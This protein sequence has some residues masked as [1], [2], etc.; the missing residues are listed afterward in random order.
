LP[1]PQKMW[2]GSPTGQY[3]PASKV[4]YR[5]E[6]DQEC[7]GP[8]SRFSYFQCQACFTSW[9][10]ASG[11]FTSIRMG[12]A[13]PFGGRSTR[14]RLSALYIQTLSPPATRNKPYG[15]RTSEFWTTRNRIIKL[16][17]CLFRVV[18]VIRVPWIETYTLSITHP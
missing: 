3:S 14:R 6:L 10:K 9:I 13:S 12:A 5:L 17:W 18:R 11:C 4:E 2:M 1:M 7:G 16:R 15:N 8:W